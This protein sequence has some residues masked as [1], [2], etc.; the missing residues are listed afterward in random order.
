MYVVM[1]RRDAAAAL[2]QSWWSEGAS[3]A[4]FKLCIEFYPLVHSADDVTKVRVDA[5]CF[6][7]NPISNYSV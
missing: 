4:Y 3:C 7:Y 1:R 5:A 6:A 2:I